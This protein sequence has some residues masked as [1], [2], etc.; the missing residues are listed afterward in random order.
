[1]G[2]DIFA[3][4]DRGAFMKQCVY[5]RCRVAGAP[6][7]FEISRLV[8]LFALQRSYARLFSHAFLESKG[9]LLYTPHHMGT[10]M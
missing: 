4:C 5:F 7:V 2:L 9:E 6:R 3:H 8:S 1:M 10:R